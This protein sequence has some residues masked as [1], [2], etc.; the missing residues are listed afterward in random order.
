MPLAYTIDPQARLVTITGEYAAAEEWNQLLGRILRDPRRGTG[1]V[2]LRDL[3]EATTPVGAE[4][5]VGI[6]RVVRR[7]WTELQAVRAAVLTPRQFDPAALVA[8]ALA[9]AQEIP[10]R[11]FTSEEEALAWLRQGTAA[12]AAPES[13]A[14]G[15]RESPPPTGETPGGR[16]KTRD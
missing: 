3:R 8:H 4:T 14:R 11:V 2:Y 7:Y 16:G 5:V 15:G 1:F 10:L 6:I 12:G 9:D 13:H